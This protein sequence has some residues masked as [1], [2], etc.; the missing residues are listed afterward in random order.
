MNN[1]LSHRRRRLEQLAAHPH[2]VTA[3]K[4]RIVRVLARPEPVAHAD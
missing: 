1:V 3:T 4:D 2:T